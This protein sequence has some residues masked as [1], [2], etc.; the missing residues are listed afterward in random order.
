MASAF[1]P[2]HR[3]ISQCRCLIGFK[4]GQ[5]EAACVK[6]E[7]IEPFLDCGN[8]GFASY[9]AQLHATGARTPPRGAL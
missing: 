6:M 9:S 3:I 4:H 1:A 5:R 8:L 2:R 7:A